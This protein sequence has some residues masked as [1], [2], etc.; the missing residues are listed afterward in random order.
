VTRPILERAP[1]V[2]LILALVPLV[3]TAAE[4]TGKPAA[5][6]A[7]VVQPQSSPA[8]RLLDGTVE[9]V[10]QATIS[11]Q[12]AGRVNAVIHDVDD[13]VA[14]GTVLMRLRSTEQAAGLS[15]A[16]A[17][18]SAAA[19]REAQAQ[20]QYR[21]IKDMYER[22]IVAKATYDEALASRDAAVAAHATARAGL[23]S[24]REGVAY[25]EIR[26]PY[27]G[28]VTGRFVEVGEAV[29]PGMP[30]VSTAS[31]EALRVIVEIPQSLEAQV[32][33]SGKAVVYVGDRAVESSRVTVF[34]SAQPQTNTFRA[35]IEL[36]KEL[37]GLAPGMFV[38][39]GLTTGEAQRLMVPASALVE[40]SEM[41]AVYV[42][43]DDGTPALRQVRLGQR[44][45]EQVEI[46][47]GLVAGER[48]AL[49]PVAASMSLRRR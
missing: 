2:A 10:N 13:R 35:R 5:L 25:T 24:A 20:E 42:L 41:R 34:P 37:P 3:A 22:K 1:A 28:V 29:A 15:Q 12:T 11:A 7:V 45:G 47:A 48:V 26:A 36:P 6:A 4:P 19:S 33:S 46:L 21:R 9:A 18:L 40:R 23:E 38:K 30:L 14:A 16:Q 44:R 31:L 43:R 8:E 27:A 39:V 17:S 32:R 49:D